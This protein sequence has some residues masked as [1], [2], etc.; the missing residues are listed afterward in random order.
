MPKTMTPLWIFSICLALL[1]L[2]CESS[3]PKEPEAPF[4]PNRY[5]DDVLR[6]IHDFQDRRWQDSLHPYLSSD[7]PIYRKEAT[8]GLAN[9]QEIAMIPFLEDLLKDGDA[10]VAAA[11]AYAIGQTGHES[12][13]LPLRVLLENPDSLWLRDGG[14][15]YSRVL[16]ALGRCGK[17]IDLD[18]VIFKHDELSVEHTEEALHT[19]IYRFAL[20]GITSTTAQSRSAAALILDEIPAAM[21]AAHALGRLAKADTNIIRTEV[22]PQLPTVSD[23]LVR[24]MTV[25]SLRHLPREESDTVLLPIALNEQ[26]DLRTRVNA[27]YSW[28]PQPDSSLLGTVTPLL[29]SDI[30]Q[31]AVASASILRAKGEGVDKFQLSELTREINNQ[32]VKAELYRWA[33]KETERTKEL[34]W[35][36]TVRKEIIS[37]FNS[38]SSNYYKRDLLMALSEVWAEYEFLS[39]QALHGDHATLR[40]G[41]MEAVMTM[42]IRDS[43]QFPAEKRLE[44]LKRSLLEKDPA[45]MAIAGEALRADADEYKELIDD[46]G[47]VNEAMEGL[48]LPVEIETYLAL[49]K[50]LWELEEAERRVR[51]REEYGHPI[52]WDLCSRISKDATAILNTN[53]GDITISLFVDEMPG[54]VVNFVE[55]A[56]SDYFD[57]KFFHRVVPNFV[58][59]AGCPRGDGYGGYPTIVRSEWPDLR[60]ETG[61]VGMASAGKDTE[62]SQIFITHSPTPHLD[63][64]YSVFAKVVDGM[65]IVQKLEVGDQIIDVTLI[66]VKPLDQKDEG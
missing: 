57:G 56:Q 12:G 26:E 50:A 13:A 54:T 6:K 16:E 15:L 30:Y 14:F 5:E 28:T 29:N 39:D 4:N 44:F 61:S 55:L 41:G 8:I 36:A 37:E 42:F 49:Q 1:F 32:R 33:L 22:L 20:R 18:Y 60:Y 24:M 45:V 62:G 27:I 9:I 52:D 7:N 64:R 43:L 17:D 65:D 51:Y 46:A 31:V 40:S 2:A 63:G 47:F 19:S 34:K 25:R 35:G 66:G 38:A 58:A 53:R 21:I 48:D 11:A 23:P 59:Q 3:T 10:G